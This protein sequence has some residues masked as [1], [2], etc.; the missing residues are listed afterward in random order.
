MS[1]SA[2]TCCSRPTARAAPTSRSSRRPAQPRRQAAAKPD[3]IFSDDPLPLAGLGAVDADLRFYAAAVTRG[4]ATLRNAFVNLSLRD[5][6]LEIDQFKVETRDGVLDGAM[7]I[8]GR[9]EPAGLVA[10]LALRKI[11]L[12]T[13]LEGTAHAGALEGQ[14][15][16]DVDLTGQSNSVWQIMASLDGS[17][18]LA[19]GAGRIRSRTLQRWVGG[20]TR[21]LTLNVG[22]YSKIHCAFAVL[23][24]KKGVATANGSLL[25]TVVAAFVGDGTIDLRTDALALTITPVIKKMTL[26]AAVP[27]HVRG[28]LANPAYSLDNTAVARRVGG[29]LGGLVF[30]PVLILGLDEMGTFKKN[31]CAIGAHQTD[32]TATP[33]QTQPATGQG[34]LRLPGKILK[35][36]GER[37]KGLFG[38]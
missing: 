7:R 13:M 1:S 17:A 20:P 35:G 8:D 6:L 36:T 30:P 27:V 31:D 38:A 21:V 26:S 33:D 2:P 11:D 10:R 32:G 23:G 19:I 4:A 29:L 12:A 9:R 5:G 37:L 22:G 24:I 34:P 25:D 14:A 15:N 16:V 28:T 3:R 18:L